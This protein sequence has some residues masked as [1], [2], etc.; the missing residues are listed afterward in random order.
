MKNKVIGIIP[1]RMKASRFPGKPLAKIKGIPMIQHVFERAKMY[2]GWDQLMI[3]T[4]DKEI[5]NFARKK[6]YPCVSTSKKHKRALDRV[7][8]AANKIKDI[9]KNDIVLCVQADEPLVFPKMLENLILKLKRG[10]VNGAVAAM[11]II[12][13]K[14]F[15]DPNIVKIVHSKNGEVLYTSRSPIPY[16]AKLNKNSHIAKRIHGMFSFRWHYLKKFYNTPESTL[17]KV[18]ACDSNR[19]CEIYG[20]QYISYEKYK[21]TYSVDSKKDIQ[22][23][24]KLLLKDKLIKF[25]KDKNQI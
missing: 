19:I 15:V 3:A 4:C 13:K 22:T 10:K 16:N 7:Y 5:M 11:Q 8:E 14:Q 21:E 20:G 12:H 25:Y 9:K 17:E 1:A 6:N 18:E 24:E 23:V 2:K